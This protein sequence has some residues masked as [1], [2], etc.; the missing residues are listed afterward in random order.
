MS[1]DDQVREKRLGEERV[2]AGDSDS[3][4]KV[5]G[6]A[7]QPCVPHLSDMVFEFAKLAGVNAPRV[8]AIAQGEEATRGEIEALGHGFVEWI[9]EVTKKG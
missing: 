8:E 3:T 6:A 1:D 4:G 7:V 5:L 2:T 9:R